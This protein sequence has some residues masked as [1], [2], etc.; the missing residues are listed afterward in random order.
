M[1]D[2][3]SRLRLKD[4]RGVLRLMTDLVE[5]RHNSLEWFQHLLDHAPALIAA[6]GMIAAQVGIPLPQHPAPTT[7]AACGAIDDPARRA[8]IIGAFST[9]TV[10]SD[11]L[12][13]RVMDLPQRIVALRREDV[14]S[15]EEWY[16]SEIYQRFYVPSGLGAT[17]TL[18]CISPLLRRLFVISMFR[19]TSQPAF[20]TQ[21]VGVLKFFGTELLHKLEQDARIARFGQ[22]LPRRE[23]EVLMLL[24]DGLS[25]KE[26]AGK[27]ELSRHTVHTYVRQ[28]F[29]R[30]SVSSRTE[31]LAAA[32]QLELLSGTMSLPA[33]LPTGCDWC[34]NIGRA[35]IGAG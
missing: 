22:P 4:L 23:E 2:V 18:R 25:E 10:F 8:F 32:F 15:D 13:R 34:L 12:Y 26:A 6:D 3:A 30:F 14:A 7:Y 1:S 9:G 16:N 19:D 27:L 20:S 35:E 31:L 28:L 5:R 21:D 17:V 29:K 24:R 11:P 33:E